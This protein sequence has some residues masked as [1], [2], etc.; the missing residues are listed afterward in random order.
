MQP[1]EP[2]PL[3]DS[4][5]LPTLSPINHQAPPSPNQS[6][7]PRTNPAAATLI[8]GGVLLALALLILLYFAFSAGVNET[9]NP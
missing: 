9:G 3:P 1:V 2:W 5:P 6:R 4:E 8:V 7:Q